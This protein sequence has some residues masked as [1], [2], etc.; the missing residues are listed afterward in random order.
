MKSRAMLAAL[1][2]VTFVSLGLSSAFAYEDDYLSATDDLV[3][4]NWVGNRVVYIFTN[5]ASAATITFK[6]AMTYRE[7]L[8]V[9]GG[10]S[11]G[12]CAGGGG[13][14]GGVISQVQDKYCAPGAT[15]SVTVGKG[16]VGGT[17]INGPHGSHSVL[18]FGDE[19]LT[20]FGGG[21]GGC[22]TGAGGGIPP[23]GAE[24]ASGGGAGAKSKTASQVDGEGYTAGQ[25][26]PGGSSSSAGAAGGGGGYSEAGS[27]GA[28]DGNAGIGGEGMT[29]TITGVA[30]VYGSG[31]GG[32]GGYS[33]H[34]TSY[35]ALGGTNA[36]AGG[37]GMKGTNTVFD[38][39]AVSDTVGGGWGDG[40]GQDAPAGFGGGGGG[41]GVKKVSDT[42]QKK[43]GNGGS[44]TVIL[45]FTVGGAAGQPVVE[46]DDISISFPDNCTQPYISVTLGGAASAVYSATVKVY[47]GTG[48][49]AQAGTAYDYM[50]EFTA[51]NNGDTVAF[52][53]G[54][55]PAPGETV[56]VHVLVSA[57]EANDDTADNSAVA[58]GTV[59]A[60]VGHGGDPARVIH[61]RDNATGKCDGTSWMDAY[62][63]FREALKLLDAT[64][65][66][67]WYCGTNMVKLT[68]TTI[69]PVAAA[70]LR[71]GFSGLE[72]A[73]C[74]RSPGARS[75]VDGVDLYTCF[76]IENSQ[77]FTLDGFHITRGYS[78]GVDKSGAGDITITNCAFEANGAG[79]GIGGRGACIVGTTATVARVQDCYF[80]GH[81]ES[82]D[83][84]G[85][86]PLSLTT[87]QRAIVEGCTFVSNGLPFGVSPRQHSGRWAN[88][89]AALTTLDAPATI[90]GSRFCGNVA[91]VANNLGTGGC[92]NGGIVRLE[93][94]CGGS[95]LTN[96]L[97]S[98]NE[99]IYSVSIA[100]QHID[101]GSGSLMVWLKNQ[102]Q[103]VDVVNCT[104]A[105][106]QVYSYYS[107]AGLNLITGTVNVANSIFA[108]NRATA[109]E[110]GAPVADIHVHTGATVNVRY[111][112]FT[113]NDQYQVDD[114]GALNRVHCLYDDPLF[115]STTNE[116]AEC[117][118]KSVYT[119][120]GQ[121]TI[122]RFNCHIR[123]QCGYRDETT[124]EIVK[125]PGVVSPALDAGDPAM[126]AKSEARPNGGRVNL[127]FYG[128]TPWA[129]MSPVRGLTIIVH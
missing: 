110:T 52:P 44:G 83:A 35:A 93:G 28:T 1:A 55:Y 106:N 37:D 101:T 98:G 116:I 58:E 122:I 22:Y 46:D 17:S 26:H 114:G 49:L 34:G 30:L 20:A 97:F 108:H 91:P 23:T 53:G 72:D 90:I 15:M 109:L 63:D 59:P 14:G 88:H 9:G 60:F 82:G 125:F 75:P 36:G 12:G 92:Y 8:V 24:I 56:Y 85:A 115:V 113:T 124:G 65:N 121:D 94:E 18:V 33:N 32:G 70:T 6:Q 5:T 68:D 100:G 102:E 89:G 29:N 57:E 39:S 27:N 38:G 7:A 40:G 96:C 76:T 84:G 107:T 123:G 61:V 86:G 10:G 81:M 77:P 16:A 25:G 67:L 73:I 4:T 42:K 51:V 74:E 66:E 95:A 31:G 11:G 21:G 117:I 47:C 45:A 127:G 129:T 50:R 64:R 62:P 120:A 104:F 112:L 48:A 54:I 126:S 19:T 41:G 118:N 78:H 103:T 87:L 128:N 111:T 43:S 99:H 13:G 80:A 79:T 3:R 119:L 71:G 105:N 2:A 69:Q